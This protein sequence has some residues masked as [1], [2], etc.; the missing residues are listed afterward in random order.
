MTEDD[1]AELRRTGLKL[2]FS[3]AQR[4]RQRG[5]KAIWR[6]GYL[7]L[8]IVLTLILSIFGVDLT[9][10]PVP[11]LGQNLDLGVF[12]IVS[13]MLAWSLQLYAAYEFY[14]SESAFFRGMENAS[15]E[16]EGIKD[17]SIASVESGFLEGAMETPRIVVGAAVI[18]EGLVLTYLSLIMVVAKFTEMEQR[19]ESFEGSNIL[20]I[21]IVVAAPMLIVWAATP[22]AAFTRWM[23]RIT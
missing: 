22:A 7:V 12:V 9:E 20:F 14:M 4:H 18:G 3:L 19:G 21:P 6:A 10:M 15:F 2:E 11:L 1:D 13:M 23:H 8:L 16:K 17:L 5:V